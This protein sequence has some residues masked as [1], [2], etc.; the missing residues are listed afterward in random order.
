MAHGEGDG[1]WRHA[2][3]AGIR[4][5]HAADGGG[6][7]RARNAGARAALGDIVFF[8]DADVAIHPDAVAEMQA[9]FA[10]TPRLSAVMG[11]YDDAPSE[12]NFWSQYKNLFHHYVH[13]S[14]RTGA[15][16]FWAGCG[17]I[18]R[19][20]LAAAGGF[21]ERYSRPSIEDIELGYRLTK[22]GHAIQLR[23]TLLATHLKRWTPI[24]LIRS[25]VLDRAIPWTALILRDR[26]LI[27]DLNLRGSCRASVMLVAGLFGALIAA[28]W[29]PS[30]IGA[31][32][33]CAVALVWLN[34]DVYRFF[35]QKRGWR[36]ALRAVPVHWAYYFYSGAA[37][38]AG[39]ALH[40][41]RVAARTAPEPALTDVPTESA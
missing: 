15:S 14:S 10:D 29:W 6:P 3:A 4:V 21:D 39:L 35:W 36:F 9:A 5:V 32:I 2:A 40:V 23:K 12:P 18:R 11:S 26:R 41:R 22:A 8:V 28:P 16:T 30:A 33:L 7:A 1:A 34:A 19:E 38:A 13:Q 27:N 37:F 20:A 24:S 25:D 31:A 17:A